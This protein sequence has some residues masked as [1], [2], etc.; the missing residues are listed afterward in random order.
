M[1]GNATDLWHSEHWW[2]M[3]LCF[4][5]T[6][7]DFCNLDVCNEDLHLRQWTFSSRGRSPASGGRSSTSDDRNSISV[8]DFM[9]WNNS[10]FHLMMMVAEVMELWKGWVGAIKKWAVSMDWQH[11]NV[12]C[13]RAGARIGKIRV[14]YP[15]KQD[16]NSISRVTHG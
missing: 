9:T 2:H 16:T 7:N 12:V 5:F 13:P 14:S 8:H 1:L 4:S 3:C 6:E 10:I 11:L 15:K